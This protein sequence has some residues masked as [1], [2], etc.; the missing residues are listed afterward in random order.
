MRVRKLQR[1]GKL[2][3]LPVIKLAP[4]ERA[5]PLRQLTG[6]AL[7]LRFAFLLFRLFLKAD[8]SRR[9]VYAKSI[10]YDRRA[11]GFVEG[12]RRNST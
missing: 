12:K 2:P 1:A 9:W 6:S 4:R 10:I 8:L 11:T 5:R 7:R 3:R